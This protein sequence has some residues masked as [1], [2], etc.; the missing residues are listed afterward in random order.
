MRRNAKLVFTRQEGIVPPKLLKS[1]E[2]SVIGAGAVG[3]FASLSIAKMGVSSIQ[4]FD[5]DGVSA[6]NLPNQYYR[7]Q[8]VG[9]F[10]VDALAAILKEFSDSKT[11]P[12]NRFYVNQR[13]KK[14]VIVATD[15]MRSRKI[16]WDQ[17]KKQKQATTYI[18]ARM[19]AEL[20]QVYTIHKVNGKLRKED[21]AF[22]EA[23]L[24]N[25]RDVPQL[26]CTAR[27]IIYNV[28][29]ISALIC[30]AY[31]GVIKREKYPREVTMNLTSMDPRS[32]MLTQ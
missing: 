9:L 12:V 3:S 1:S 2:V 20:G 5:E 6:H 21:I 13:L 27:S 32:L 29:M 17:F 18:E 7:K 19:G 22:Y 14:T 4:N 15:S 11:A 16:V 8:D 30:R 31:K 26:P 25:D 10:K 23:R 28:L 24:Y